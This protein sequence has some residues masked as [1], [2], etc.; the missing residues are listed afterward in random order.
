MIAEGQPTDVAALRWTWAL[1]NNPDTELPAE[2]I[3]QFTADVSDWMQD[4]VVWTDH[5][6]GHAVGMVCLTHY[7]RMPSPIAKASGHW[8]YLGHLYVRPEARR[9]GVG[10]ALVQ[11][12]L[13]EARRRNYVKVVLSPTEKSIP[14]Y[15]RCGFT[16]ENALMLWRP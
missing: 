5:H 14:L 11:T 9:A 1:E 16:D 7:A 2:P 13:N 8:G 3:A 4:R 15:L 10:T 12:V 6:D